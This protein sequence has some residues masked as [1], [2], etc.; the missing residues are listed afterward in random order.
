M[1]L[2]IWCAVVILIV[3]LTLQYRNRNTLP[4]FDS[5]HPKGKRHINDYSSS[6]THNAAYRGKDFTVNYIIAVNIS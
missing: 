3:L 4:A 1:L 2:H 6:L 5:V